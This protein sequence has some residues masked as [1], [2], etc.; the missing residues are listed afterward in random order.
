MSLEYEP[1]SEPLHF[2]YRVEVGDGGGARRLA[3]Q[4]FQNRATNM[5]AQL[6]LTSNIQAFV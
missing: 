6:R 3:Q 1:A 5:T 2:C 4:V